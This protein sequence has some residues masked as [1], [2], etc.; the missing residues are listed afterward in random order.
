MVTEHAPTPFSVV[1]P[2]R[3]LPSGLFVY[4]LFSQAQLRE[5]VLR[6]IFGNLTM[7]AQR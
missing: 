4:K 1:G 5:P 3:G 7:L 6:S 2:Q